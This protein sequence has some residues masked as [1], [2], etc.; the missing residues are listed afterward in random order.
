MSEQRVLLIETADR[1]L[2]TLD[3]SDFTAAGNAVEAA[4]LTSVLI[5]ETDGGFGGTW[6]D[7]FA[8]VRLAGRHATAFP[9]GEAILGAHLAREGGMDIS[10]IGSLAASV[11]GA[12][13]NG[14]FTGSLTDIPWGSDVA[15]VLCFVAGRLIAL[16]T[17]TASQVQPRANL[18]AERRDTLHFHKSPARSISFEGWD[19]ERLFR[20]MALVRAAQ[21]AGAL[22]AALTLAVQYTRE[23]KQFGRPLA[24]FQAIQQQLAVLAEEAAAADMAAAAGFHA[25]DRGDATFECAAAKLRANQ[26]ASVGAGIAHQVHG[27]MG[28]TQEYPLQKFTRRLW[29]WRSEYGNE[30]HWAAEIGARVAANGADNF[31][32]D[33]V[34]R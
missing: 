21:I 31:W 10:G 4:G 29:A 25:L 7:A 22:D 9:L 6:G 8:V 13:D 26:A 23:R 28:F 34:A 27:A 19:A 5:P 14:T 15:Q 20:V 2:G 24:A 11:D 32:P 12:F 18:A 1:V 33:L 3:A 17:R 16:D 30:R